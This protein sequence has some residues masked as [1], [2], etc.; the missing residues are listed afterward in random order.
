MCNILKQI[1]Y[2]AE[3]N[4]IFLVAAKVFFKSLLL[5]LSLSLSQIM[6]FITMAN[7][8]QSIGSF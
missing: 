3:T 8:Q 6:T 5:S 7:L 4:D 2:I 1:L